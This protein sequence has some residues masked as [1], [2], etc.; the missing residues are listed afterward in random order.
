MEVPYFPFHLA[1]GRQDPLA[2]DAQ[3]QEEEEDEAAV[4]TCQA[5]PCGH[6]FHTGC[7]ARW[8]QQCHV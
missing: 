3:E 1:P 7:I 5:L 6:A 4:D 2:P 8:L